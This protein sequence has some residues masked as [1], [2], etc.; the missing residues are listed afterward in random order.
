M[1]SNNQA[2]I[3]L[4]SLNSLPLGFVAYSTA[5][6]RGVAT[7]ASASEEV[8]A[9]LPVMQLDGVLVQLRP[10][11][12][13]PRSRYLAINLDLELG[14][15]AGRG[16]IIQ[17]LPR[18]RESLLSYF[19]DRSAEQLEAAGALPTLKDQLRERLNRM[20]PPPGIHRVFITQFIIQ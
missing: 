13:E 12:D 15:E 19:A 7:Q 11:P 20:L 1:L 8:A 16:A 2:A 14:A 10:S 17:R 5:N 18:V 3:V 4:L 6:P 9:P